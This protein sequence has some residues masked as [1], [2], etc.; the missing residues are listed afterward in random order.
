MCSTMSMNKRLS[1][2][3]TR[4]GSKDFLEY[5]GFK[6]RINYNNPGKL[7]SCIVKKCPGSLLTEM[8]FGKMVLQPK[9]KHN[10]LSSNS[11]SDN[12]NLT[13]KPL[14][15]KGVNK[16]I[17]QI[18]SADHTKISK[19]PTP[20]NATTSQQ[21]TPLTDVSNKNLNHRLLTP[22]LL[23]L[24]SVPS[25]LTQPKQSTGIKRP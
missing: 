6:Y 23:R 19:N 8:S 20:I 12:N 24:P 9:I 5:E 15:T 2:K 3:K 16:K 22:P 1:H 7:W 25:Y 17:K 21:C 11:T 14:N 18:Q 4:E 10:H 13:P